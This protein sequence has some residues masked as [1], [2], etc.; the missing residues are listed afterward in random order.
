MPPTAL[1]L[2]RQCPLEHSLRSLGIGMRTVR[3]CVHA[4]VRAYAFACAY[5]RARVRLYVHACRVYVCV[6]VCVYLW[7]E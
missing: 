6:C 3:A 1:K 2:L 5:V 7:I 4:R